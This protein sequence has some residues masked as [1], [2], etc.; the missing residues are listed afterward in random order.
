MFGTYTIQWYSI[1][2]YFSNSLFN[3]TILID[4]NQLWRIYLHHGNKQKIKIKTYLG[5]TIWN[6]GLLHYRWIFTRFVY[7][8]DHLMISIYWVQL[9]K[10]LPAMRETWFDPWV[11]KNPWRRERLPTPVFWTGEFYGLY[12]PWGCNELNTTEW[13]SLMSSAELLKLRK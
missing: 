1:L 11:G 2:Q 10:N 3:D 5:R 6:A 12:S 7:L 8:R 4:W 13:L 9:V